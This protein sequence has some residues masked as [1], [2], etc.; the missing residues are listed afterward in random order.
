[1]NEFVK[2]LVWQMAQVLGYE[3]QT[4]LAEHSVLLLVDYDADVCHPIF[5]GKHFVSADLDPGMPW[6]GA[7]KYLTSDVIS[8]EYKRECALF[9][10][11]KAARRNCMQSLFT[12]SR[13]IQELS[14]AFTAEASFLHSPDIHFPPFD[15]ASSE[16]A[17]IFAPEGSPDNREHLLS[18]FLVIEVDAIRK[19]MESLRYLAR[20][21]QLTGL[22]NRHM[23]AEIVNDDPSIVIILDIDNFKGI[24][25]TYGHTAGD[26]ALCTM[27]S[28]LEA[29]FWQPDRDLVFRLVP[30]RHEKRLRGG[31]G[32]LPASDLRAGCFH[33]Q[34]RAGDQL[35][36]L[37]RI[38]PLQRGLQGQHEGRGRCALCRQKGR[39]KRLCPCGVSFSPRSSFPAFCVGVFFIPSA[40]TQKFP[41]RSAVFLANLKI[42]KV[43]A[44]VYTQT[45]VKL[46]KGP[47]VS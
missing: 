3:N 9:F 1:M 26:E 29:V 16:S 31:G 20:H 21:D 2:L 28:R 43:T 23:M 14:S 13:S 40:K 42:D 8:D 12:S 6:K 45:I 25:D 41:L 4:D 47:L 38:H 11:E 35:L 33:H 27:S 15:P 7:V 30:R 18:Y 37:R 5:I 44:D 10:S 34:R 36:R 46:L 17:G 39:Q 22:Y 32:Q 24:N 19:S